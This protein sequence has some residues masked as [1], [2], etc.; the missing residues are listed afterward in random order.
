MRY[1]N[2]MRVLRLNT[3]LPVLLL[4]GLSV[5]NIWNQDR[6]REAYESRERSLALAAELR[7]SS[8]DLTRLA[9]TYV[10]TADSAHEKAYW[11]ILAVRN[12]TLARPD[13][14]LL[15]L[16]ELM[17]QAGF[18]QEEFSRLEQAERN[19]NQLVTTETIAMNAV[20]GQYADGSGGYTRRAEPDLDLARRIMHDP[21][22]HQDKA[23]IM[24]PIDE[25]E[26]LMD[27]RTAGAV[28]QAQRRSAW[29]LGVAVVL[30]LLAVGLSWL[31]VRIHERSL[32]RAVNTIADI[33]SQV[34]AGS[35][36]VASSSAA[37]SDGTSRQVMG[38]QDISA[39][40][41]RSVTAVQGTV[42]S[43]RESV[44]LVSEQRAHFEEVSAALDQLNVSMDHISESASRIHKINNAIDEVAF[45]TNILALNAAVE[46]ARAGQAGAGFA[47]VADEV[48]SLAQRCA[49]AA[50]E[51]S[52]LVEESSRRTADGRLQVEQVLK[53]M[54]GLR[55]QSEDVAEVVVRV[56][57]LSSDQLKDFE[58]VRFAL[59]QI[60]DVVH[61]V[62]AGSEEGSVAAEELATLGGAML[63]VVHSLTT[64]L[65]QQGRYRLA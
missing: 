56:Q 12:G 44:V 42:Q 34:A 5:F 10:V 9:R 62:A 55:H 27:Q 13:G 28:A 26:R 3:L 63:D 38:I 32:G 43:I 58:E 64:A 22:Y 39:V 41:N 6:Y 52:E 25:F 23:S 4:L 61:R 8:E 40:L 35:A 57:H 37:L 65:G 21:Q 53:V 18:T 17:K 24:G 36:Q 49:Q 50:R 46:A 51:A 1:F 47:V 2:M 7:M 45:Q 48:R 59:G 19:S 30:S 20:K 60:G 54:N 31:T 15:P 11:D 29:L 33:S 14:Q 16:R